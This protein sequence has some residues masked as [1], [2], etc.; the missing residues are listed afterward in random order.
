MAKRRAL[1]INPWVH[2]FKL[3]DEW[4]HPIGL[5]L[6]IS[7]LHH[8]GWQVDY[9]NCL[10]PAASRRP[11]RWNTG[12]FCSEII[13]APEVFALVPR[14]YKRYGI[15]P[16]A[17]AEKLAALERPDAIF[18][19]SAMTYWLPGLKETLE[20]VRETLSDTPCVCGGI[21]VS[22]MPE[23]VRSNCMCQVFSGPL[24][25]NS[26]TIAIP[27]V[28]EL[29]TA[30]WVPSLIDG[31][32]KED[33]SRHSPVLATL[34]CPMRCSYCAS[35]YLQPRFL[36][37]NPVRV[38]D[39]IQFAAKTLGVTDF[40]FFD[41]ALLHNQ[42]AVFI[43]LMHELENRGVSARFH[44]PNGIHV[45]WFDNNTALQMGQNGFRT[46][47]FG[48][49]S[50]HHEFAEHTCGKASREQL[51]R[52]VDYALQTMP[53]GTDIGVY[54]MGGLPELPVEN[55]LEDM[56]WTASLGAAVKPVFL[57]PV[58]ESALFK[59]LAADRPALRNEPLL[60][61]DTFFITTLPG[62]DWQ[63][64]QAIRDTARALNGRLSRSTSPAAERS[65]R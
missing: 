29:D 22:L 26:G 10:Q 37:R 20:T 18:V 41:D 45:R 53:D 59:R 48:Y 49:E 19:G 61:N 54:I 6:L 28:V 1:V 60:Q 57:S 14:T 47:R 34:G 5:Y 35:G 55:M 16:G 52:A 33:N 50:G 21:A 39:E 42:G 17:L 46:I 44:L 32:A 63:T 65:T 8:N 23:W 40:A 64:V 30:G 24:H 27:G 4:M 12:E 9:V 56:T 58:P 11:K 2:D 38:C 31:I 36:P 62:W 51:A 13:P 3:Y 7:L 43:P 15:L 25:P